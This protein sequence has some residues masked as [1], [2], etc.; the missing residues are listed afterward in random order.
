M[1][2][3]KKIR[4]HKCSK[5]NKI[6]VWEYLPGGKRRYFFC[7]DCVPRGCSCN[8]YNIK[9]F[10]EKI[11]DSDNVMWWSKEDYE[12]GNVEGSLERKPDSF[13]YEY[14]DEQNRRYPCCEYTYSEDG[15]EIEDTVYLVKKDDIIY[16][17]MKSSWHLYANP[18]KNKHDKTKTLADFNNKIF[19]YVDS[20]EN[21]LIEYN[22][23]MR[24]FRSICDYHYYSKLSPIFGE[25]INF[26]NSFRS[27]LNLCRFI[28]TD[29]E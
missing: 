1:P 27:A 4:K 3:L 15:F 21:E 6:A 12:K 28:K 29:G 18:L 20:F 8:T 26:Y 5:C 22:D 17:L 10:N 13:Y 14:L 16:N 25:V 19:E 11:E 23:F 2:K 7:D 24:G 9:E